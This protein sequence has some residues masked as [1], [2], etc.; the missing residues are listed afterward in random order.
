MPAPAIRMP[1]S[2]QVDYSFSAPDFDV[3]DWINNALDSV[4]KKQP[5]DFSSPTSASADDTSADASLDASLSLLQTP[6]HDPVLADR[7]LDDL[8]GDRGQD[9][10][11][12]STTTTTTTTTTRTTTTTTTTQLSTTTSTTPSSLSSAT[13]TT[14]TALTHHATTHLTKLHLLARQIS[15]NLSNTTM[16]VVKLLPRLSHELDQLRQETQFLQEGIRLVKGDVAQVELQSTTMEATTSST[17]TTT[18]TTTISAL[19]RLKY[20][21]RIKTRMEATHAALRE[22]ENWRNLESEAREIFARGDF[23]RGAMRLAEA[24]RS[25]VVYKNTNVEEDRM[26]LLQ[27]LKDQLEQ[28]VMERTKTALTQRDTAACQALMSVFGRI[29]R[30]ERFQ[31]CYFALRRGPLV[32]AW[33]KRQQLITTTTTQSQQQHQ[34]KEGFVTFLQGFYSDAATML[35]DEFA[36]GSSIFSE[37]SASIHGLVRHL[38]SHLDPTMA[39]TLQQ[40][41]GPLGDEGK[42]PLV[43][44]AFSATVAFGARI[45]RVITQP[46]VGHQREPTSARTAL[47][48]STS[49]AAAAA[50]GGGGGGTG[51]G[52]GAGRRSRSGT[53]LLG[54]DETSGSHMSKAFSTTSLAE[55][56]TGLSS[57]DPNAWA[58]ILYEPFLP[59]QRDYGRLEAAH[60]R[61]LLIQ[62]VPAME[63]LLQTG[64]SAVQQKLQSVKHCGQL[65]KIMTATNQVAFALAEAAIGRCM[66]L[67]HGFG[68]AGLTEG[69]NEF[70]GEILACL[71]RMLIFYRQKSGLLLE[72]E[73][74]DPIVAQAAS[75]QLTAT[76]ASASRSSPRPS[77]TRYNNSNQDPLSDEDGNDDSDEWDDEDDG[78][79][80]DQGSPRLFQMGL[81][82]MVLCRQFCQ[83]L[84]QLDLKTKQALVGVE[85]LLEMGHERV[86]DKS[87]ESA[88]A[89]TNAA[90]AAA[91]A[92]TA[93]ALQHASGESGRTARSHRL[94]IVEPRDHAAALAVSVANLTLQRLPQASVAL[95]QQS[96]LNSFRLAEIL[97]VVKRAQEAGELGPGGNSGGGPATNAAAGSAATTGN[98]VGTS[99]TTGL[100]DAKN[101]TQSHNKGNKSE[102]GLECSPDHLYRASYEGAVELTRLC[103]RFIFDAMYLPLVRPLAGVSSLACW[104][105][106]LDLHTGKDTSTAHGMP[107]TGRRTNSSQASTMGGTRTD[108]Y[109]FRTGPSDYME[110]VW[111]R[112][113]A[114]L[115]FSVYAGDEGLRFGIQALPYADR[116]VDSEHDHDDVEHGVG[117]GEASAAAEGMS[118]AI[119]GGG[120]DG[121]GEEEPDEEDEEDDDSDEAVLHRWMTSLARATMHTLI[122]RLYDPERAGSMAALVRALQSNKI[123][124]NSNSGSSPSLDYR[125]RMAVSQNQPPSRTGSPAH[126]ESQ[127]MQRAQSPA[128]GGSASSAQQHQPP[129][130]LIRLSEAGVKQL[131]T[132]LTFLVTES[133]PSL[134]IDPTPNVEALRR[135]L[136]MSKADLLRTIEQ[137]ESELEKFLEAQEKKR[138]MRKKMRAEA[139]GSY[140]EL[141][142]GEDDKAAEEQ[143]GLP[144]TSSVA[145]KDAGSAATAALMPSVDT[146]SSAF[147]AGIPP[148]PSTLTATEENVEA[149]LKQEKAIHEWVAKLR[150][151]TVK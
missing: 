27:V 13:T 103:Q 126:R 20:L 102:V 93:S 141:E 22:A 15:T 10:L 113:D 69:V 7:D 58:Y 119:V 25:L 16:D 54:E 75:H 131:E 53:L 21:D 24:E 70:L 73:K 44:A 92:T 38:F 45:E 17:T 142:D 49:A 8:L 148:L 149:Y 96:S 74:P 123:N 37:P 40:I 64:G 138:R 120:A 105:E 95:L 140:G 9:A 139:M 136:G 61:A 106:G 79:M 144:S 2:L 129:F 14:A 36:W 66:K 60:L 115:K 127:E 42:L 67:T 52:T 59:Y 5:N 145:K 18:T 85:A 3:K 72:G 33:K 128:A 130:G 88:V 48:P 12:S 137:M 29:G 56:N 125:A 62:Q 117:V 104:T 1:T 89:V 143:T 114:L 65:V 116:H 32:D 122:E 77:G 35:S 151:L 68:A 51:S 34:S 133:L 50:T 107:N 82:L 146:L 6:A 94:S 83:R 76:G 100:R 86:E 99:T 108:V 23:V 78:T 124:S 30:Q 31:E 109:R 111:R 84:Q 26:A 97:G 41:A 101:N 135:A 147:V 28:Q 98:A 110:E 132:D 80:D 91:A 81:R 11:S 150:G 134:G 39:A 46:L 57:S 43:L 112:L 47:P 118:G 19:E 87:S 55:L 121:R 4:P 90:A 63:A 71:K